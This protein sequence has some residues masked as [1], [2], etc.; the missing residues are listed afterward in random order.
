MRNTKLSAAKPNP[1]RQLKLAYLSAFTL[2]TMLC[3]YFSPRSHATSLCDVEKT[4]NQNFTGMLF[5]VKKDNEISAYIFGS[6][7]RGYSRIT[8]ISKPVDIA[9]SQSKKL[10]F[11]WIEGD[12]TSDPQYLRD[13]FP[14]AKPDRL[15][16]ILSHELYLRLSTYLDSLKMPADER[17][18]MENWHP[19]YLM[20]T[21]LDHY[22]DEMNQSASLDIHLQVEALKKKIGMAGIESS[23]QHWVPILSTTNEETN[24]MTEESLKEVSC[25]SCIAERREFLLCSAEIT[26]IGDPDQLIVMY[27]RFYENKPVAKEHMKRIAISRNPGMTNNIASKL[28]KE[29]TFFVSIGALHLGGKLGVLQGLRDLGYTVE[30]VDE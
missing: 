29:A 14:A 15:K 20:S 1:N 25:P 13:I 22:P 23:S 24:A 3:L 28:G 11:E 8:E 30:K 5:K 16:S 17:A 9:L 2:L 12:S 21:L 27:D 10:Y 7:H 19:S 6:L 18:S 4:K 26:R